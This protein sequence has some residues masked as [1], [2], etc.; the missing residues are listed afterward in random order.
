M[1]LKSHKLS[2][3]IQEPDCCRTLQLSELQKNK[4]IMKAGQTKI[5]YIILTILSAALGCHLASAL[6]VQTL[7]NFEI[8][9]GTVTGSLVQ[10]PDGNFY[11]TTADGG[12]MRSGT[13]FRVTPAGV[14][15]TLVSDQANPAAGLVVGNDGFLYGM[16]SAGGGLGGFGTVFKM[17]T[18][19]VLTTIAVLNG[20]N[21]ENPQS[22]L[23]LAR[24]GNFYG[25]SLQGGTNSVG[26]VF[27]V[28]PA[29]VV[30]SLVSF[31][32]SA[33]GGGPT[34][35][36][37][38]GADGNL[39]GITAFGGTAGLG[40]VFKITTG[41]AFTTLYSFQQP[42]GFV[43]KARLT[44]GPDGNLYG[45]SRDGGSADMGTI[46]KITPNG[47]FTNLVSFLGTNGAVPLAELTVG[48]DGQLYGTTQLGGSASSGTV[49]KVTTNGALTILVSFGSSVNG[50]NAVPQA[51]LLAANDGN[52]YGCTP[53]AVFKVTPGGALTFLTSLI[54]L[55]GVHP[56]ANLLL[57]PDGN[58]YGTTREGGSNNVGAIFRL[59]TNGSFTSIF[60]FSTTNGLAPQG[61]LSLGSDGNFYGTTS[62][63]GSNSAGTVFR[64]STNGTL[65]TLASLGG[66]RGAASQCQLVAGADGSF[67]GTAPQQGANG[68]GIVF[69]I[70]TNGVFTTLVSFNNTNGAF[71]VDG[72]TL[73]QD[74]NFYGT[75]ANGGSHVAGTVFRMTP[76]GALTTLFSFDNTN[77]A[78]PFGGLVLGSDGLLYGTTAFGGTNLSFGTLFRITT[79]GV[80]TTL[81]NFHFTDGEEPSSKMIRAPDGSL[82]GTTPFGGS[83]PTDPIGAD[84]GTVFRI[85]TNGLFTPLLQ[86]D[87]TNGANPGASLAFG[88]DGN[89]Y[90]STEN[91]GPGGGGT[92][93]RIVLAPLLTGITKGLNGSMVVTG[94]GAPDSPF[95]L[96]SSAD[97]SAPIATWTSLTSGVLDADGT[98]SFTDNGAAA[99]QGRFYRLSTP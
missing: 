30:T 11:G 43:R 39:Y 19:G 40:T 56:H 84:L 69:R 85:T 99:S 57:G 22:G 31:D 27:R 52:F 45:T 64:F 79:N 28:T 93:F 37:A 33:L 92:L 68:S 54:S 44:P 15:T 48:A 97:V 95:R 87:G 80:L 41:G 36:L 4:S 6:E 74:G 25:T 10:A 82:Y 60:S 23:V 63:G 86:F 16:T 94:S 7:L 20:V 32:S 70:T 51:G 35:G 67:Y 14:L 5:V 71:P 58:F 66:V 49:F 50:F 96:L 73:G 42:D 1:G 9:P 26:N 24:D 17:T 21:G 75:T 89:L 53:G 90:G 46:Y 76:A 88:P 38:L 98:F 59:S 61:G 18:S 62:Q 12:P 77:G 81:F 34:A 78:N 72:L 83:L 55:N 91:G 8:G 13:V 29:G 47:I 2:S 3:G 65:T